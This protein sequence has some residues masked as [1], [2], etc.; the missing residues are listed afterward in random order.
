MITRFSLLLVLIVTAACGGSSS[1]P[2]GGTVTV[3][4]AH[5]PNL[6]H[7][8]AMV[9][10]A[11]GGVRTALAPNTVEVKTFGTGPQAI[12][13]LLAG[14]IDIAYVGPSPA[15]NGYVK[16]RGE[17]LRV[18][19]GASSGGALFVIRPEA[20]IRTPADLAGKRIATPQRG[21]T[22]DIALRVLAR[23][24]GLKTADEGGT[25]AIVPTQ[26]AD[27]LTSFQRGQIDG[28]WVAEPWGTRLIQEAGA[29]VW[30][31]ERSKWPGERFAT[32]H[33]I[34]ATRFLEAHP[35]LVRAFLR[36]HV[37][38]VQWIDG[39]QTEA[40]ALANREIARITTAALPPAVLETAFRHVDYTWDPL[41]STVAVMADHAFQLGFLGTSTPDL[42]AL[43]ALEPLN[44]VLKEKGLPPVAGGSR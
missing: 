30:F 16:S 14:E 6:T 26:P 37:D 42:S 13:A 8:V 28:A 20:G 27:I 32:T 25:F 2:T 44:A 29:T 1:A 4:V 24:A 36:A 10:L 39:H 12:E 22:Q 35:D 11:N 34:V 21:G 41:A 15:V 40:A 7:A 9:A 23:D 38:A 5:F 31:D 3:R 18:I 43:Y 17:A 19:A 33:V